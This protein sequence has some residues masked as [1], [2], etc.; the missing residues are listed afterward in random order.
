MMHDISRVLL[1]VLALG[2]SLR[3]EMATRRWGTPPRT[4]PGKAER[5]LA[6]PPSASVPEAKA[7]PEIDGKLDDAAWAR[8]A[9]ARITR[10]L[11]GAGPAPQ[12]TE[13]RLLR[14]AATLYVGI[15]CV[16]PLADKLKAQ[17]RNPDDDL[18]QDDSVEVFLGVADAYYH[19]GVNAAGSTYDARAK[20]RGW[21]S[22]F[23]AAAAT[24]KG[25][26]T[27]E[28][29]IPLDKLSG[30]KP[31]KSWSA[32]FNRNRYTA[33]R[34]EESAWS[35]TFSGDSHVPARFG[36]LLFRDP[37]GG[38][39]SPSREEPAQPSAGIEILSTPAGEG[40]VR[41]D[42]SEL[43]KSARVYRADLLLYRTAVVSGAS[44][45]AL[46]DIGVYALS[47]EVAAG[48]TPRVSGKPLTLREPLLDRLDATDAVRAACRVPGAQAA[49]FVRSCPLWQ[50]EATC[51]EVAYEGEAKEVPPP[52]TQVKA[53]H[54]AGQTFLTWNE[55]EPLIAADKTTWGEIKAKL[56]EA[57]GACSYRI[58]AHARPIT[59]KSLPDATLLA[60]VGPLSAYNVNARNKEYLIGQAMLQ[61]DEMG[62][63][64]RDYNGYMHTWTMDSPRMDRFPV[65]RFV[66]D[67]KAGPLPVGSGLYVHNPQKAGRTHYAVVSARDGVENTRD[68][69]SVE[70]EETVGVGE[71]VCQGDGLH[72]PFFDYPGTRKAYVHWCAPPLAPRPNMAF[73]WSVLLPQQ[74]QGKAP[75]E[76]YFHPEG[77]SYAQP[78]KK[79]LRDS[80]QIAPH[81]YPASNWYG[82]ND[83]W[84]T[85]R[86]YRKGVVRNHTQKRILAFLDWATEA[87]A[88]D[89]NRIL[90]VGADGAAALALSFPGRFACVLVTGFDRQ[91]V[92]EPKA[93]DKFAAAWGVRSPDIRD[94]QGRAQ[95]AWAN[96]DELVTPGADLP[97]FVCRGPSWGGDKGWGKGWGRFYRAMLKAGQ[98][99]VA[100]WAWGGQLQKPDWYAGLWRGIELR[101][102]APVPAFANC[103]LDREGEG[104]GNTNMSFSWKDIAE[105]AEGFE[106][107][108]LSRE[109]TFDLTPRRLQKLK[110]KPGEKLRWEA[111]P[112]PG[113]GGAKADAQGGEVAADADG[114][115]TLK[116]L[117]IPRECPGLKV[118]ITRAR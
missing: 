28:L 57:K 106:V 103:S 83:S 67:E 86:S 33:G 97:L 64:A 93:A 60:E 17:R 102:D 96:L 94:D 82:L 73:N 116:G 88:I 111:V 56:A 45:E 78:G 43:P 104:G 32:N 12:A 36:Q 11:D 95:W 30:G 70:V 41:F 50:A 92:L 71:P 19:F 24:G 58:Y 87:L 37:P 47:D 112:L 23:R 81:D 49:F 7:A 117:T 8:A 27:A 76:L 44:A 118:A 98:P 42:L 29:A 90:A 107:T 54:H 79:M 59:A 74:I 3:A 10:T 48:E 20:D 46:V 1:V 110:L 39:T 113:R 14:D 40:V 101:R 5:P 6:R 18:W 15:R 22:G 115:V 26:W 34:W 68:L 99:L 9:A 52:A 53:L 25:E 85:L 77:Y 75:A 72:G 63:L 35:P 66:I 31:P 89:P 84:G 21:N 61:S 4:P 13:I 38:G 105:T 16:E 55:V 69:S 80:V 91:G 51:L 2:S 108:V 109:C 100:H 65:P 114:F 62:E